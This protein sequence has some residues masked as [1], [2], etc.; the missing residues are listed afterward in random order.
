MITKPANP[1]RRVVLPA[2]GNPAF[3]QQQ[4]ATRIKP[5]PVNAIKTP[6]TRKPA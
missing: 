2:Q 4:P 6:K 3:R 1:P 5:A